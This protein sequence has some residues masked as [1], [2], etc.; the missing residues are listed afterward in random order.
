MSA[1]NL[2]RIETNEVYWTEP[3]YDAF[4]GYLGSYPEEEVFGGSVCAASPGKAKTLFIREMGDIVSLEYRD[5]KSCRIVLR[6]VNRDPGSI[7][8]D[9]ILYLQIQPD[10]LDHLPA[11]E[12]RDYPAEAQP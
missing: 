12:F 1:I 8:G 10:I 5:I 7:R 3:V 2:Y 6:D 11:S 4:H 9:D